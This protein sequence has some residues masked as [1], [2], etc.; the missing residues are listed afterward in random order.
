MAISYKNIILQTKD[1]AGNTIVYV[2][3]TKASEVEGAVLTI[4]G[5]APDDYGNIEIE[6]GD[7]SVGSLPL[8]FTFLSINPNL[9]AGIVED[10]GQE[11]SREVYSALW[12]WVK[13][14]ELLI[15]EEEWQARAAEDPNNV[16]YYSNGDNATTFRMPCLR[17][18]VVIMGKKGATNEIKGRYCTVAFSNVTNAGNLDV[19]S[20][21]TA[22]NQLIARV[23]NNEAAIAKYQFK[24]QGTTR[25]RAANKTAYVI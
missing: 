1:G 8:G 4:N 5:V 10:L 24:S 3:Y 18:Y 19:A 16:P 7:L 15:T 21:L 14:S 17:A 25:E 13:T 12:E 9:D 2:P 6:V 11:V 22:L 23:S 20:I